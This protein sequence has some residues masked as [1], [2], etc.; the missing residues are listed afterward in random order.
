MFSGTPPR[1]D[2]LNSTFQFV[3]ARPEV[4]IDLTTGAEGGPS[5]H[6]AASVYLRCENLDA[7]I[8]ALST[9]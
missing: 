2:E 1:S 3:D 6:R 8:D 9:R 4:Q 7:F 5:G